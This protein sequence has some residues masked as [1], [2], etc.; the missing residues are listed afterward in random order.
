M[1]KSINIDKALEKGNFR[2]IVSYLKNNLHKYGALYNYNQLLK[3]FT[4]KSFNSKY[5]ITYLKNKYS[6]LYEIK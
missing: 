2:G 1:E 3:K 6:K 4:G 5:Y